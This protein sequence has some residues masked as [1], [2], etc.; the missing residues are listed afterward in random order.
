MV[1]QGLAEDGIGSGRSFRRFSLR[2]LSFHRRQDPDPLIL[3]KGR[4]DHGVITER[5]PDLAQSR[6]HICGLKGAYAHALHFH[7]DLT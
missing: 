3:L 4:N 6:G 1:I 5:G 7:L 2:L